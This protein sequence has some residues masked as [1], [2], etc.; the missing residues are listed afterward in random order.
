MKGMLLAHNVG[1]SA[2]DGTREIV[3]NLGLKM[4]LIDINFDTYPPYK[5]DQLLLYFVYYYSNR[6]W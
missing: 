5:Q 1:R 2:T 4:K 3:L 6:Y